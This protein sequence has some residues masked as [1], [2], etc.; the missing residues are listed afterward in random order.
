MKHI[1]DMEAAR[2]L[3]LYIEN[4]YMLYKQNVLPACQSLNTRIKRGTYDHTLAVKMWEHVAM[5]GAKKY[6]ADYANYEDFPHVFNPATRHE[7][8][9]ELQAFFADH[10]I[11][12]ED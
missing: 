12:Y 11:N 3:A 4:D 10:L 7:T 9:L 1:A 8:A 6:I 2:E 5:H